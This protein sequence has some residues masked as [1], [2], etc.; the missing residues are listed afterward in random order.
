VRAVIATGTG[1]YADPWHRFEETSS[2]LVSVLSEAGFE[3]TIDL[4]VDHALR[5]LDGVDLVVVNAGD[6]WRDPHSG[7]ETITA[8]DGAVATVSPE[9]IDGL[10]RALQ[11]GIGV[12]AMHSAVS[13]LRDY[14]DWAP[15]IGAIWVPGASFHPPIGDAE[16]RG[17]RLTRPETP[18]SSAGAGDADFV[19]EGFVVLDERYCGLQRVGRSTVVAEHYG[20]GDGGDDIHQP[21]V[22]IRES[23]R[24][25]IAVDV[26]G[27]DA[28]SY[29]SAGHRRVLRQLARWAVR[30][31]SRQ[32]PS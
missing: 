15:A 3:V 14:P 32:M 16:V 7:G 25:R 23:G 8:R 27:H 31:D 29:D 6:P 13:S 4:D 10:A 17:T 11:R 26:L 1:R 28:R 21:A 5:S 24:A 30:S 9:S 19:V 20:P 2:A 22:W 12:L 18:E